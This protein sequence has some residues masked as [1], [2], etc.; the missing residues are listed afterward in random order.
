MATANSVK[1]AI[2]NINTEL[3]WLKVGILGLEE[4]GKINT[5]KVNKQIENISKA[6]ENAKSEMDDLALEIDDIQ[7]TIQELDSTSKEVNG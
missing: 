2:E 3:D 6:I 7:E 4:D 1:E 5:S